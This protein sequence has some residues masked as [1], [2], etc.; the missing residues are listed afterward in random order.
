ML[1]AILKTVTTTSKIKWLVLN[2]PH[3]VCSF[4]P[5]FVY[6]KMVILAAALSTGES[7]LDLGLGCHLDLYK[8]TSPMFPDFFWFGGDLN[9]IIP[10]S[11]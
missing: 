4:V 11:E 5:H 8:A 6:G 2:H 10:S 7:N 3:L 9:Y 1:Y